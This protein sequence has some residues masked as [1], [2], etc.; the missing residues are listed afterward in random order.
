M[1]AVRPGFF[2]ADTFFYAK[3][4]QVAASP[5][6]GGAARDLRS[7]LNYLGCPNLFDQNALAIPVH[8]TGTRLLLDAYRPLAMLIIF[9]C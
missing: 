4:C 5:S 3:L 1:S 6:K 7:L 8:G 9:S 2:V